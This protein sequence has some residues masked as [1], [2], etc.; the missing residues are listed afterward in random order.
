MFLGIPGEFWSSYRRQI[1]RADYEIVLN[2]LR[3]GEAALA[4]AL[5]A[6]SWGSNRMSRGDRVALIELI[7][8]V[9]N[10]ID[11]IEQEY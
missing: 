6:G 3:T 10:Y 4:S 8:S 7:D 5:S 1:Y 9:R 2:D 11:H